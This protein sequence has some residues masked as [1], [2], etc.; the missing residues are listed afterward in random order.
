LFLTARLKTAPADFWFPTTRLNIFTSI[1]HKEFEVFDACYANV[2]QI[3][4]GS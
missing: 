1:K 3:K 2:S 4:L